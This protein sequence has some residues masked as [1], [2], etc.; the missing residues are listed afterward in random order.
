MGTVWIKRSVSVHITRFRFAWREGERMSG[1]RQAWGTV[2]V[3]LAL[4][5][6]PW[7]VEAAQGDQKT[8]PPAEATLFDYTKSS[9]FPDVL[10]PYTTRFVPSARLANSQLL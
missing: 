5:L 4:I 2:A 9:A 1:N 7:G 8:S 3:W 6:C 10:R